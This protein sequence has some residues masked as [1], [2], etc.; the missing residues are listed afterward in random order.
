MKTANDIICMKPH[1]FN[2]IDASAKVDDAINQLNTINRSFLVVMENGEYKGIFCERDYL[3]NVAWRGWDPQ[4]V[5]V[6][7][8]MS[9][10]LPMVSPGESVEHVMRIMNTHHARYVPV[11]DGHH[12]EGVITL[13]GILRIL[14]KDKA[15]AFDDEFMALDQWRSIP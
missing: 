3:H 7:D 14:L 12:F 15:E 1:G 5:T 9:T 6:Q 4:V 13:H 8:V 10:N 2:I 11:F